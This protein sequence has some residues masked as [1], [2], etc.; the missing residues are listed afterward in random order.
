MITN[1]NT[2][3]TK[4]GDSMTEVRGGDIFVQDQSRDPFTS[5]A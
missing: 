3:I 1:N 2:N 5:M 4:G